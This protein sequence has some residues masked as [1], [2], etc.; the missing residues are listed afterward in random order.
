MDGARKVAPARLMPDV[1]L[2]RVAARHVAWAVRQ[3]EE[4]AEVSIPARAQQ[5][6]ARA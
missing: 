5:G 6:G 1:H 3:G 2:W 4:V